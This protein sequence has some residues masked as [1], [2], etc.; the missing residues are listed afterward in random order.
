MQICVYKNGGRTH[1]LQFLQKNGISNTA[2]DGGSSLAHATIDQRDYESKSASLLEATL[3]KMPSDPQHLPGE[4]L[5][6][7]LGDLKLVAGAHTTTTSQLPAVVFKPNYFQAVLEEA[8]RLKERLGGGEK[9]VLSTKVSFIFGVPTESAKAFF[10]M[11][12]QKKWMPA[13]FWT[14][15]AKLFKVTSNQLTPYEKAC[16]YIQH[17]GLVVANKERFLEIC[18]TNQKERFNE[19][20]KITQLAWHPKQNSLAIEKAYIEFTEYF[21]TK[22]FQQAQESGDDALIDYFKAFDG[23]CF[24]DRMRE[25]ETYSRAHPLEENEASAVADWDGTM[26]VATAFERELQSFGATF[27]GEDFPAEALEKHFKKK[28][29]LHQEFTKDG[30][31]V[32]PSATEMHKWILSMIDAYAVAPYSLESFLQHEYA[33][34]LE[35]YDDKSMAAFKAY[36]QTRTDKNQGFD[37]NNP[38]IDSVLQ[39]L[40][41]T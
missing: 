25:L 4:L 2:I 38:E 18:D 40:K 21:L 11:V 39:R 17:F 29:I 41:V 35:E 6:R 34:F 1:I 16:Q 31:K 14:F 3:D 10:R 33:I 7:P 22:H 5:E 27:K 12:L 8:D 19:F 28:G 37:L 9:L 36:L 30:E 24:E 23:V 26:K 32:K 15:L 20:P 13:F